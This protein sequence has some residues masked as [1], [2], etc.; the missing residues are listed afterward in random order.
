MSFSA[1]KLLAGTVTLAFAGTAMAT[2]INATTTGDVFLNIVNTTNNTSFIYDTGLSQSAFSGAGSYSYNISGDSNLTS[3]L[4]ETG[5]VYYYSVVSVTRVTPSTTIIDITGTIDPNTNNS[6][7]NNTAQTAVNAFLGVANSVASTTTNSAILPTAD[8]WNQALTEG[9]VSKRVFNNS[10][11]PYSDGAA[12][13]T[14]L[15]YYSVT[16]S[17]FSTF[18][19]TW[20]FNSTTDTLTYG[21][22]G[23]PV[24]LPAPVW[25]L[26]SGLGL[27]GVVSRRN[28]VAA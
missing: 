8:A 16:G 1:I 3:F 10:Q 14:P 24:P 17:T 25:L 11:T 12:L 7:N 26:V 2:N 27:M 13:D 22:Q 28:K 21:P 23:A 19:S 9:V 6:T 20:D 15:A 4:S 5:G 18:A